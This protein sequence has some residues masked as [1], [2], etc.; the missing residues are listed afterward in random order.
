MEIGTLV[1]V[2]IPHKSGERTKERQKEGKIVEIY[3][4]FVVLQFSQGYKECYKQEELLF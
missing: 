3:T 4:N 2:K 1:K